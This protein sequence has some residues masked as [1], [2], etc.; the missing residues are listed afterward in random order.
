MSPGVSLTAQNDRHGQQYLTPDEV[1]AKRGCDI[2]IVGRGITEADDPVATAREYRRAGWQAYKCIYPM[3]ISTKG[4]D[5][6]G[7]SLA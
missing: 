6:S 1:I 3:F 7:S 4:K 5:L 2:I